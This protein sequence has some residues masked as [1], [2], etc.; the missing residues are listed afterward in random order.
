MGGL[1]LDSGGGGDSTDGGFIDRKA[2]RAFCNL[3]PSVLALLPSSPPLLSLLF[4]GS[5]QI[6]CQLL[7]P[8][9]QKASSSL[10]TD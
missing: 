7:M 5:P 2:P 10:R 6:L 8:P 1:G 4:E 3:Q 9:Q